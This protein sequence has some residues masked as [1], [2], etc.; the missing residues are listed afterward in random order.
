M[1]VTDI[2]QSSK[3]PGEALP[4]GSPANATFQITR[5]LWFNPANPSASPG[6]SANPSAGA[7]ASPSPG[8]NPLNINIAF[9]GLYSESN[10]GVKVTQVRKGRNYIARFAIDFG[11]ASRK[12]FYFRVGN[13]PSTNGDPGFLESLYYSSGSAPSRSVGSAT[14]S[15]TCSLL[16]IPSLQAAHVR[17]AVSDYGFAG[18]GM[19]N[20][21][22][23]VA[24]S[25]SGA[26]Y[27]IYYQGRGTN[28]QGIIASSPSGT[29]TW[30]ACAGDAQTA[31]QTFPI[32]A[33]GTLNAQCC[34]DGCNQGLTCSGGICKEP[35]AVPINI[36]S[37]AAFNVTMS[38]GAPPRPNCDRIIFK[39]D[40]IF[41]ADAIRMRV[42]DST[43]RETD[44]FNL[45]FSDKNNPSLNV[46]ECFTWASSFSTGGKALR[47]WPKGNCPYKPSGNS[48][49]AAEFYMNITDIITQKTQT[50]TIKVENE[51]TF[52]MNVPLNAIDASYIQYKSDPGVKLMVPKSYF[53]QDDDDPYLFPVYILNNRQ[54]EIENDD[55]YAGVFDAGVFHPAVPGVALA[56][57]NNK[58]YAK[59]I[60]WDVSDWRNRLGAGKPLQLL[61]SNTVDRN[62]LTIPQ[63]QTVQGLTANINSQA[64]QKVGGISSGTAFSA[65]P[66]ERIA[67]FIDKA[68]YAALKGPWRRAYNNSVMPV[69][70]MSDLEPFAPMKYF[71]ASPETNLPTFSMVIAERAD[72]IYNYYLK[73]VPK[74]WYAVPNNFLPAAD[75]CKVRGGLFKLTTR[76]SRISDYRAG[77]TMP[78]LEPMQIAI[79][80]NSLS[81]ASFFAC[82]MITERQKTGI[83]KLCFQ[84][85]S[86]IIPDGT[87]LGIPDLRK[88]YT[89]ITGTGAPLTFSTFYLTDDAKDAQ[90]V[91]LE[92]TGI[93]YMDEYGNF[94]DV[95]PYHIEA[96]PN[97]FANV[98]NSGGGL[99]APISQIASR[100]T[101]EGTIQ[102]PSLYTDA[103]YC[104][105][106]KV[107]TA[108]CYTLVPAC[109]LGAQVPSSGCNCGPYNPKYSGYCCDNGASGA[110]YQ[111]NACEPVCADSTA[112]YST[113]W[114]GGSKY[115]SGICCGGVYTASDVCPIAFD[116]SAATV[117]ADQITETSARINWQ[118]TNVSVNNFVIYDTNPAV[119]PS[120][121]FYVSVS[122]Q[123]YTNSQH[124]P[125]INLVAG[126][127][128][129]YY[130]TSCEA[131]NPTNCVQFPQVGQ[132]P[133]TFTTTAAATHKE[134]VSGACVPI[135]GAGSN[136]CTGD[137]QCAAASPTPVPGTQCTGS[138]P[139]CCDYRT[140]P[141]MTADFVPYSSCNYYEWDNFG[142]CVPIDV[143]TGRNP[144]VC[145]TYTC[146]SKPV[147]TCPI[148]CDASTGICP[149]APAT[150]SECINSLCTI[151]SGAGTN[152][153]SADSD[154]APAAPVVSNMRAT[155]INENTATIAW[156]TNPATSMNLIGYGATGEPGY[157]SYVQT[158]PASTTHSKL[159]SGLSVGTTYSWN[160]KSCLDWSNEA[161][162]TLSAVSTFTTAACG[163]ARCCFTQCW[164]NRGEY[165]YNEKYD[166]DLCT[167][168]C[169]TDHD[170]A[171]AKPCR[172]I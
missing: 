169:T 137:A 106:D 172:G 27:T 12:G 24:T 90:Q 135:P 81:C 128:Y 114:C 37:C 129:Y 118:T 8:A 120:S 40:S 153:C 76:I 79:T 16:Q 26:S 101:C 95:E 142:N 92:Y 171:L 19:V 42:Y 127:T 14:Y 11:L 159:I 87:Q 156:D 41:P 77:F 56:K 163:N 52:P 75:R 133:L 60:A 39:V 116:I 7:T 119:T 18:V 93:N 151:V 108:E 63:A 125:L 33:C 1:T 94:S 102:D 104:C 124:V 46:N 78:Y 111:L 45:K 47:Y 167:P 126:T 50:I 146:G 48:V 67:N 55:I 64:A 73:N 141:G 70:Q 162:C 99:C 29:T 109:T 103:I 155:S 165:C 170:L 43:N 66:S 17:E 161:T 152:Q 134:C 148:L 57:N 28:S 164:S 58:G 69:A 144:T 62:F 51:T 10:P 61:T 110:A 21:L 86:P 158:N 3:A 74:I 32:E 98:P 25:A 35:G 49:P 132:Q 71:V 22:V 97:V 112:F 140:G 30:E 38:L 130:V 23:S 160:V 105:N 157:G 96:Y 168:R 149:A 166:A 121:P 91:G 72:T 115:G 44:N 6:A 68:L 36:F 107:E 84:F 136:L 147:T 88:P 100:C 5:T 122:G 15:G 82:N 89:D 85:D 113:C 117:N 34:D 20:Y 31:T 139:Y 65:F 2:D 54:L 83:G 4:D 9:D 131:E 80:T 143:T 123:D 150:H 154:C 13:T 145:G 59:L 138:G 53:K